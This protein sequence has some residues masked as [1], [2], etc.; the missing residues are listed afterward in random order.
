MEILGIVWAA[1]IITPSPIVAT[2][3]ELMGP[4]AQ[5]Q[6]SFLLEE[7]VAW[8]N[9]LAD[10]YRWRLSASEAPVAFVGQALSTNWL[11]PSLSP[12]PVDEDEGDLVDDP[13]RTLVP[14]LGPSLA[15]LDPP[16][17][18]PAESEA[19][20]LAGD[21]PSW[22]AV[23]SVQVNQ[24]HTSAEWSTAGDF[25]VD[26]IC[27]REA[28]APYQA[29]PIAMT[30]TPKTQLWVN[31]HFIGDVTGQVTANKIAQKLRTLIQDE[32]LEPTQIRPLFGTNVVGVQHQEDVLFVVDETLRSHPEVPATAIAI[33]WINNLRQAFDVKPLGLAEIQM[34]AQGLAATDESLYGI[35]SWYGPGFHG[36]QTANGEIFDENALTAAHKSLPFN[37]RLKVTNR[38]NGKSIVVRINDRGP[39]IGQRSLDLSRAAAY[40]LGSTRK[41]VI[42]YEAVILN[43]IDQPELNELTTAQ[44]PLD[45]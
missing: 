23:A 7:T 27:L 13:F 20:S 28:A 26:P 8:F 2:T 40:C 39:Y 29:S 4:H 14:T 24:S 16:L 3:A 35:A 43:P 36:R 34:A 21:W 11:V 30:A 1:S 38:L 42:P 25:A 15:H 41:G 6:E 9:S 44:L 19:I 37:T 33:Q 18:T 12:G 31:N 17:A 32:K 10:A 5:P 45:E 22:Q